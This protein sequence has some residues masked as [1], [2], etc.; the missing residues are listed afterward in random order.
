MIRAALILSAWIGSVIVAYWIAVP[1][2]I[3]LPIEEVAHKEVSAWLSSVERRAVHS[4]LKLDNPI[5]SYN[6]TDIP[7]SEALLKE[8]L[9]L[10]QFEDR[11]LD[12][13]I[14]FVSLAKAL[15]DD[16]LILLQQ[17]LSGRE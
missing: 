17:E 11:Y 9:Y 2:D 7:Y 1:K 5:F 10:C 13:F 8:A 12:N 6:L 15:S 3:E 4:P 16:A 14:T